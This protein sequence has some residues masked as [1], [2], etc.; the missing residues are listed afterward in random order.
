M[1]TVIAAASI[2]ALTI[3][4]CGS[5]RDALTAG[6][7]S[8]PAAAAAS[9]TSNTGEE[10]HTESVPTTSRP[11]DPDGP[12]RLTSAA[13]PPKPHTIPDK[14]PVG[15][16]FVPPPA[17]PATPPALADLQNRADVVA[18]SLNLAAFESLACENNPTLVA[19]RAHVDAAFGKAVQAGLWPNPRAGYVQEQIGVKGT[20]GEFLGGFV[21]QEFVT[22]DKLKLSRAKFLERTRAA[23]WQALAQEYR[24]LNDVRSHYFRTL[25]HQELVSVRKE[26]LKNAEDNV[27]TQRERYNVGQA[28]RAAVH[29]ANVQLQQARLELLMAQ[30]DYRQSWEQLVTLAGVEMAI[31]PLD[32]TL[33]PETFTAIEWEDALTRL[34]AESPELQAAYSK[35]R[36][37]QI[38]LQREKVEP[39]PNIV[40]R[41]AGGRNYEAKDTTASLEVAVEVPLFDWN[42]GTVKQAEADLIRQQSEIRRTELVLRRRLSA[43]Y[44]RYLTALQH[45]ENYREVVLPESRKAYKS[46]L[47]SYKEN[48]LPW[49]EALHAER[50]YFLLRQQYIQNLMAWR[51]A[52]VQIVGYLLH[53]GLDAPSG[54]APPG[55]IDAVPKPR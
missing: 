2:A 1:K 30:N 3:C 24:V 37:D 46:Q 41:G 27:L 13:A 16:Q 15:Q 7:T 4:G 26:L 43:V 47:K 50:D 21:Q 28:N 29:V 54:P 42:Q 8:A 35:L 10:S 20:P 40:V 36:A 33:E 11:N 9:L 23:E 18:E 49:V 51:E 38:T 34:M 45:V 55:H 22:A 48:R 44:R 12:V 14:S 19:A 5:T 52:E 31:T 25:A 32:G 53:G 17:I 39:I 6:H